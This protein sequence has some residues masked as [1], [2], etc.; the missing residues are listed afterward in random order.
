M[1]EFLYDIEYLYLVPYI[2]PG[3][4]LIEDED[5]RLLGE[6]LGDDDPLPLSGTYTVKV[7][8]RE[9]QAA[10]GIKGHAGDLAVIF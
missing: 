5:S 7:A 6:R 4:R 2:E 8:I 10:H 1:V 9:L 3:R